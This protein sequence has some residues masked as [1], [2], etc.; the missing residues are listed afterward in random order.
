[1]PGPQHVK[2]RRKLIRALKPALV[3]ALL[4]TSETNV[5]W[6]TGFSGD[7]SCL[8]LGPSLC[9]LL[10][11]SRY[12]TQIAGE[13]P[14]VDVEIRNARQTMN[15][16][17]TRVVRNAGIKLLG[18]EADSTTWSDWNTATERLPAT[19]LVPTRS[20]V[21]RFRQIKDASE[22]REIRHAVEYAE[23]AFEAMLATL[24][25]D[26][27]ERQTAHELEHTMRRL[28]AHSAAFEPI[29]AVGP[30]AALPHARA[31][32]RQLG[33]GGHVLVDWG[34]RTETGYCSDLTRTLI[35]S[36][37]SK[38]LKRVYNTVL[39]AQ[40]AAIDAIRPGVECRE[41]DELA[42]NVI[43]EAGF[44]RYFGHSL[45]H[46]IGLEIHE[47]PRLSPASETQLATGMV[48]TVEPGIYLP[49]WGGVRI[50]DD[51]LVTASGCEVLTSV[52][53]EFENAFVRL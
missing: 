35:T 32:Y 18:F 48:L 27:T 30:Q 53:R 22:I 45:G 19:T 33:N 36:R 3:E 47:G 43:G 39:T 2:R 38:K 50:E 1:M 52:P 4:V 40:Q 20:L 51:V 21:E 15:D 37:P 14:D 5:S 11:D 42:R 28:G 17:L 13:C 23:R 31:G 6:L 49:G 34:G 7:S 16:L 41:I 29:V 10:S 12:S 9:V 24:T 46:G 44:G 8:L 26:Q 25:G